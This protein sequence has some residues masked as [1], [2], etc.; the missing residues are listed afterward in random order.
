M[1]HFLSKHTKLEKIKMWM[2]KILELSKLQLKRNLF[3]F[4]FLMRP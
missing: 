3:L 2:D 4:Y 1:F